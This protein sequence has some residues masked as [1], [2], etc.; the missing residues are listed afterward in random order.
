MRAFLAK[1]LW[2]CQ[3]HIRI[4]VALALVPVPGQH[5]TTLFSGAHHIVK[6]CIRQANR[7]N[8]SSKNIP[9]S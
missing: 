1:E 6:N 9:V 5:V 4:E 7:E 2:T 3:S 8:V